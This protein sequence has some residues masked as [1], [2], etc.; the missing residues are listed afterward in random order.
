MRP[1]IPKTYRC[2]EAA[3]VNEL[4]LWVVDSNA[5]LVRATK[6]QRTYAVINSKNLPL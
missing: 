6:N 2:K 5:K 4:L 3:E 1:L